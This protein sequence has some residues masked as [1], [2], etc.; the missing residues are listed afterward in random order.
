MSEKYILVNW[1]ESQKFVDHDRFDE[2]LI[3]HSINDKECA[4]NTYMVPEDLYNEVNDH[5]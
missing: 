5:R 3:C 4:P 1:P 2:C